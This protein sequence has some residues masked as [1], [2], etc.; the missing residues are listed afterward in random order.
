MK[1][2]ASKEAIP[3]MPADISSY[4]TNSVLPPPGLAWLQFLA[5]EG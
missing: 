1:E 2:D 4:M 3:P 5:T